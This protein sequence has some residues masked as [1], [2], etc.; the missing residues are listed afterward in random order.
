MCGESRKEAQ[1]EP[2]E[3]N[4]DLF[5]AVQAHATE[6]NNVGNH[7]HTSAGPPHTGSGGDSGVGLMPLH[8]LCIMYDWH[9]HLADL[10]QN[11]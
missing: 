1:A 3:V 9:G 10:V 8:V 7:Q 4:A 5:T 2:K 11:Q 6:Q